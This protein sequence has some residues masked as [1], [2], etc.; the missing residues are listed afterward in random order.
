MRLVRMEDKD[1]NKYIDVAFKVYKSALPELKNAKTGEYPI[2]NGFRLLLQ[3]YIT[4][5]FNDDSQIEWHR[6]NHDVFIMV[7]GHYETVA[8]IGK[9]AEDF[10]NYK[11]D[12]DKDVGFTSAVPYKYLLPFFRFHKDEILHFEPNDLHIS[13]IAMDVGSS[14]IKKCCFKIVDGHECKVSSEEIEMLRKSLEKNRVEKQKGVD[15]NS[16]KNVLFDR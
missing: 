13:Q 16:I 1:K 8:G 7:D 11:F 6:K 12:E 3:E 14:K 15:I 10:D 9:G 2:N 4:K 5:V